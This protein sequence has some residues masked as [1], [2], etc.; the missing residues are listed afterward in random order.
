VRTGF[1]S[2][3]P[4]T[5]DRYGTGDD[6]PFQ[7]RDTENAM[8]V[9]SQSDGGVIGG[10]VAVAGLVVALVL[11]GDTTRTRR[12]ARSVYFTCIS[13]KG[14]AAIAVGPSGWCLS[15]RFGVLA[16]VTR[17]WSAESTIMVDTPW[18]F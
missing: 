9:L 18:G 6:S 5:V 17:H 4:G 7:S 8:V 15:K 3:V 11:G 13:S 14:P 16:V 2:H 12:I 10:F 1:P